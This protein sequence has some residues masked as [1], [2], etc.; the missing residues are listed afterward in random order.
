M[1]MNLSKLRRVGEEMETVK[2]ACCS[3]WG[4]KELDTI[5]QVNNNSSIISWPHSPFPSSSFQLRPLLSLISHYCF[6]ISCFICPARD[7]IKPAHPWGLHSRLQRSLTSGPEH[8]V[9][10]NLQM[11][12]TQRGRVGR[13]WDVSMILSSNKHW[14]ICCQPNTPRLSLGDACHSEIRKGGQGF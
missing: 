4:H 3:S 7:A 11:V 14:G 2:L 5:E 13:Q 1:D 10:S 6:Y 9:S 12:N 8:F